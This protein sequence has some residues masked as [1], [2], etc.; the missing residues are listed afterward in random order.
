MLGFL[1]R[2]LTRCPTLLVLTYRDDE[3]G[4]RHR[5]RLLL[6]E[7]AISAVARRIGLRPLSADAVRVM[8]GA[9]GVDAVVLREL[10]AG[11]PFFLT[12]VLS[13]PGGGGLPPTVSDAVLARAA[14]LSMPAQLVLQVAAVAD[15]A[16]SPGC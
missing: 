5:L 1:A 16:S 7:V 2:R 12:E 14:R 9:R 11:N 13:D 4:P 10:T 8:V 3:L 6:G 15:H